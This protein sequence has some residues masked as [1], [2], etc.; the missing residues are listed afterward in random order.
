MAIPWDFMVSI[1]TPASVF[2]LAYQLRQRHRQFRTEFEDK[3]TSD[4]RDIVYEIP[5]DSLLQNSHSDG[6]EGELKDYY[7][8]IDLTND[9]IHMRQNGRVSKSTWEN[10][11][12]GIETIFG[13]ED[14]EAA[15][16]EIKERAPDSYNEIRDFEDSEK[17]D[18]PYYWEH[19]WRAQIQEW[20]YTIR[21]D[22]I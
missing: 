10:W 13:R 6:Y 9:Q 3:L 11:R 21:N 8:Y 4:Y 12:A 16:K 5:V 1:A 2:V 19:P 18:D 15:W 22:I 7:R 17:P 20:W 14:F